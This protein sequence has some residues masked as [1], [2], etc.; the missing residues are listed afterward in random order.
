MDALV[1]SSTP[2]LLIAKATENNAIEFSNGTP[3]NIFEN[4][5]DAK[6]LKAYIPLI[7]LVL[8][9]I[10]FPCLPKNTSLDLTSSIVTGLI[11]KRY[12]RLHHCV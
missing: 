11:F 2:L 1:P 6:Q 7:Q 3:I 12:W 8:F 4:P 10:A 9:A 5:N